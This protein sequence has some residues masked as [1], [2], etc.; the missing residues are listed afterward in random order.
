MQGMFTS[1]LN[2]DGIIIEYKEDTFEIVENSRLNPI[3]IKEGLD[4][5]LKLLNRSNNRCYGYY[6]MSCGHKAFL[7][8]GAIRKAK[9]N[10]FK[11]KECLDYKL[12]KEAIELGLIY[13]K[14]VKVTKINDS[15]Y[16]TFPCGHS[17]VLKTAN[18]RF[19][20][21]ACVQCKEEQYLQEAQERGLTMLSFETESSTRLYRLACGHEKK[22][23]VTSVREYNFRC[24]VCQED[25]YENEA[26]EAGI[27][28]LR[29]VKSSHHDYRVYRLRCGC[30]KEITMPCVRRGAFECK[31]HQERFID[32][33]KPISVYLLKFSLPIGDVLKLGF[34]MDVKSRCSRY[35]LDGTIDHVSERV[36]T[37][38]QEAVDLEKRLHKKYKDF[39]LDKTLMSKYMLNGFTECYPVELQEQLLKDINSELES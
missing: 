8:Y 18:V 13:H 23:S 21:V 19:K 7:H 36:F 16:Y 27:T 32:F 28:M 15:R 35:Y 4:K 17:R 6:E 9:T 33:S 26:K 14:H 5:E 2:E 1:L 31:N 11:C 39:V 10:N 3:H 24:R 12:E 29:D 25:R 34:A 37:N 22:I 20:Q 38:G 30:V